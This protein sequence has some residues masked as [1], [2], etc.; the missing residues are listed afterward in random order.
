MALSL[1]ERLNKILLEKGLITAEKLKEAIGMQR[2]KGGKLSDILINNGLIDR[3][4]L[5]VVLSEELGIPPIN[6]SRYK[7]DPSLIQLVPRKFAYRYKMLPI[8]RMGNLLTVAMADPLNIF[9]VDEI[10][11]LTGFQ[12]GILIT[13]DKDMDEAIDQ[14]YG[15][16]AHE[17]IE[18]IM[19]GMDKVGRIEMVEEGAETKKADSTDLVRMTQETPVVAITNLLLSEAVKMRASDILIEPMERVLRVRYRVDGM[20]KEAKN[21][22]RSMHEAIVSRL[23]VMS[24]L[25][26]SE[27]RLPQDGRFKIRI[28][29]REVDFRISVLPSSEGE[30][31]AMR[32]LDK[33]QA[34]LDVNK[35]GFEDAP[36]NDLKREAERPHGMIL[37][38]GPT[39]CGKTTTL[40]SILKNIDS[41][42]KNIVTVEDPVEYDLYGINQVSIRPEIGLTFAKSLRS[43]LRQDPDVIMVGEI[44]DFDTADIAIKSALTGHLVLSTLHTTTAPGAVIRLV[45]MGV[46]PFL[47]TSSVVLVGAQRLARKICPNCKEE[48]KIDKAAIERC[49]IQVSGEPLFYRGKG[50]KNCINTGYK[51]RVGL[52]ET[53]VLTPKIKTLIANRAQEYQIK[54]AARQ[55]G[56]VTLRENGLKKVLAGIT[57]WEEV[58][59]LTTGDQDMDT[60]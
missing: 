19:E 16:S 39:G 1:K 24:N 33:S 58:I 41:P 55:E 35:L 56:M 9:A 21:P 45:N 42:E 31:A 20:L 18:E 3:K 37:V 10:K 13:T 40:Y 36:L 8:S 12:I 26:I 6:L 59:R 4:D 22:P 25:N 50:C 15:E 47:I 17:A 48:Y 46:E 34:M 38:C 23:K 53:L 51:G 11:T 54:E 30:K 5:M 32:I 27:R 43:I 2:E 57:T 7:I 52:M 60:V 29:N 28:Q 49:N 44:R 14:Y